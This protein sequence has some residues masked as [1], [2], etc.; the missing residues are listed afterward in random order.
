[1][2]LR[3]LPQL[4]ALALLVALLA[5]GAFTAAHPASASVTAA[6]EAT[7]GATTLGDFIWQ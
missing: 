5:G 1:M 4:S 2:N 3:R 7:G 6:Q